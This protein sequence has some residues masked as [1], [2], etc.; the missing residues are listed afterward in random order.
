MPRFPTKDQVSA[1]G[2]VYRKHAEKIETVLIAVGAPP[3]WQLPKGLLNPHEDP[4]TAALREVREETGLTTRLQGL[5]KK[6]E[7]WYYGQSRGQRVRFHK[8][9]HFYLLEFVSGDTADHDA[10]VAEARWLEIEQAQGLLAFKSE[11][12]VVALAR[13]LLQGGGHEGGG[14]DFYS[15]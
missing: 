9:V 11:Q 15:G 1:G 12:E 4:E 3:R 6:I 2:V 5:L 8:V 14:A 10:E 13:S 7:Y